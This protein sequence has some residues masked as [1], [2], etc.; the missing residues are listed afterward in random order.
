MANIA[1]FPIPN[2]IC[3]P[4]TVMPLHVFE[5]RYRTM[6]QH[7]LEHQMPLAV[8]HTQKVLRQAERKDTLD[9]MLN[10]NQSTYKPEL[11]FSAGPCEL[12]QTLDDGRMALQVN[13]QQR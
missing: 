12:L 5:P 3:F 10:S 13:M 9:E 7:C 2:C 4:G 6:V 11:V 8:C 1:I